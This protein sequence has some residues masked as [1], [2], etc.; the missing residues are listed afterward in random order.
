MSPSL[1]EEL[2]GKRVGLA[3]SAGFF[4]FFAHAGLTR[5]LEDAGVAPSAVSGSSAGAMVG[6]L[7]GSGLDAAAMSDIPARAKSGTPSPP[8]P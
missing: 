2:R 5:A 4:G 7:H 6:A 1:T 8:R 3:L